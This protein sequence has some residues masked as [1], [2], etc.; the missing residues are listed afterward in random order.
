MGEPRAKKGWGE[1]GTGRRG[2]FVPAALLL[3]VLAGGC[4]G[5]RKNQGDPLFGGVKP[6]PGLT[7]AANDPL[8]PLPGPT[9]TGSTAALAAVNPRPLDGSHDLRI[10]DPAG[11]SSPAIL[12]PPVVPNGNTSSGTL[13]QQPQTGFTPVSRQ[14]TASGAPSVGSTALANGNLSYEE[15]QA[16]LTAR[17]VT[18]QRLET[19]GE[20]G[21]WRFS[22]SIPNRQNPYISRTYEAEAHDPLAAIHGVLNQLENDQR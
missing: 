7:G 19:W 17:G 11:A 1:E 15:A 2:K 5:I 4:Q 21:D 22:C 16:R 18:W 13:L 8:P 6:Q 9:T 10:P 14:P 12:A 3:F 20:Q